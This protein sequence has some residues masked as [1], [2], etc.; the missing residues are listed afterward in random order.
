MEQE[1]ELQHY[2]VKQAYLEYMNL[3]FICYLLI[4]QSRHPNLGYNGYPP[5]DGCQL[6][7]FSHLQLKILF[8]KKWVPQRGTHMPEGHLGPAG[9][10]RKKKKSLPVILA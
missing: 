10:R 2:I 7:N 6:N 3:F 9:A 1:Q 8:L 4:N 5:A